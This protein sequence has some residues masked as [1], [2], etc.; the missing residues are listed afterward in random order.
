MG[1][2]SN[3]VSICQYRVAGELP[4]GELLSWA[5]AR[6]AERA[7]QPIEHNAEELSIGWVRQDDHRDWNFSAENVGRDHY[8]TFSLRRD[9]RRVPAALLRAHLEKAERQFLAEHP[10]LHRV[11]KQKKEDLRDAERGTLLARTLTA[12][13]VYDCVW[14]TRRGLVLFTSLG[15]K[16]TELFEDQFKTTFSGLRLVPLHP[17]ARGMAVTDEP[18]Q[19]LLAKANRAGTDA[20]LDLIRENLW[21]GRDFLRWLLLRTVTGGSR[22]QVTWSGPALEGESFDAYLDDR[23]LL[24]ALAEAGN[25]RITVQGSQDQFAEVRTALRSGKEI[26]A[27]TLHLEKGE[28]AW[29]LNLRGENFHF[30]GFRSP[31][32]KLEKDE[33]TDPALEAQAVFYQRMS[34]LEEGLQLFDSLLRAF[35]QERLGEGWRQ[36]EKKM[37]EILKAEG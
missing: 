37:E 13:A 17:L 21:L 35:L 27:A 20:V 2:L 3:T 15:Q 28:D 12:P 8:L 29:K 34:L 4:A 1:I 19:N 32:V 26:A 25:Q 11:P 23:F 5:V 30:A 9:Q 22:L 6:L 36:V 33:S 18:L 24:V 7:F 31:A 14:D 16:V 10:G